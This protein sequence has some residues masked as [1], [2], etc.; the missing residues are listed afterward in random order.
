[1]T[2]RKNAGR[3]LRRGTPKI[4]KDGRQIKRAFYPITAYKDTFE[5]SQVQ[6]WATIFIEV[7]GGYWAFTD[8]RQHRLWS[9]EQYAKWAA[10]ASAG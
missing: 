10:E 2:K 5:L 7:D 3:P 9:E 8:E 1:M 4:A 6:R